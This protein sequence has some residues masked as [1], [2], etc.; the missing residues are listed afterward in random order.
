MIDPI[1]GY[2]KIGDKKEPISRY[3]VWWAVPGVGLFP[4]LEEALENAKG[5]PLIT[6]PVAIG[7]G[8]LYEVLPPELEIT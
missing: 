4:D 5:K 6:T 1:E 2:I 7:G 3:E 8:G